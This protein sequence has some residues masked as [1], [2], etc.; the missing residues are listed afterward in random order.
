MRD[1]HQ[2][3]ICER[4]RSDVAV[5]E[6]ETSQGTLR[7]CSTCAKCVCAG[8]DC[9]L[10]VTASEKKGIDQRN[11]SRDHTK[12]WCSRCRGKCDVC[13][14]RCAQSVV[15]ACETTGKMQNVCAHCSDEHTCNGCG[16]QRKKEDYGHDSWDRGEKL[17]K[18]RM[19]SAAQVCKDAVKCDKCPKMFFDECWTWE[20]RNNIRMGRKKVICNSCL[21]NTCAAPMCAEQVDR[22]HNHDEVW[23]TLPDK[24]KRLRQPI[25]RTCFKKGFTAADTVG[26][27][28]GNC[29]ERL[30]Q[31]WYNAVGDVQCGRGSCGRSRIPC[32]RCGKIKGPR[33]DV[34]AKNW[35]GTGRYE[36]AVLMCEDCAPLGY[37]PK[38]GSTYECRY[39]SFKGGV[40][41]FD[42][43]SVNNAKSV[44]GKR[45]LP[46]C[47]SQDCMKKAF[48]KT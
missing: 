26:T 13:G 27:E 5:T 21:Q 29:Q 34:Q 23:S 38:D 37:T 6:Q 1:R 16:Q 10:V 41:K 14:K 2:C 42:K 46:F 25:C 15:K 36:R 48:K 7:A 24:E 28:C 44:A 33:S 11:A 40:E 39:C 31:R 22:D 9:H 20:Q 30:G 45:Q 19:C 35:R 8:V 3:Q 32:S 18:C 43:K 47:S 17:R 4:Q 12:V